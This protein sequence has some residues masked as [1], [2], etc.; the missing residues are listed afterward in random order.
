MS[1]ETYPEKVVTI[2]LKLPYS[3]T[4]GKTL[5]EFFV[6]LRDKGTIMGKSCPGCKAV[7]FPPRK[8]C[9]RCYSETGDWV[10]LSGK[11]VVETFTVVRYREPTLPAK[12]PYILGQIKL[13]GTNGGIT[14]LV[15]GVDLDEIKIGME[16]QA[17]IKEEREGNI[18]DIEGF[19][20]ILV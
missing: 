2:T 19:I 13:E 8:T 11:G 10:E 1:A 6:A 14:H 17:V 16:V 3:Y 7:L 12:P 18:R 4:V 20:P 9:G 5:S 15:K